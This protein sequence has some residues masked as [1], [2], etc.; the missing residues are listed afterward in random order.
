[1]FCCRKLCARISNFTS[2]MV[3]GPRKILHHGSGGLWKGD[4]RRGR[5]ARATRENRSV[6][7][8]GVQWVF[9]IGAGVS[10]VA[11]GDM[12]W[13]SARIKE[14]QSLKG[15]KECNSTE[16]SD[17]S[18]AAGNEMCN[19]AEQQNPVG[20]WR[21]RTVN[22]EKVYDEAQQ[23]RSQCEKG[24][25]PAHTMKREADEARGSIRTS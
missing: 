24:S 22:S 10:C 17:Y 5:Q 9:I 19:T 21:T 23:C 7:T 3:L 18:D 8:I 16:Y 6:E 25:G 14:P 2:R 13:L 11:S 15:V 12:S 20:I 4:E 1:M